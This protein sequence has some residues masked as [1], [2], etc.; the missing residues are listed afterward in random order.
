MDQNVNQRT[1]NHSSDKTDHHNF[2]AIKK[3]ILVAKL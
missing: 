2:K 1:L 3:I